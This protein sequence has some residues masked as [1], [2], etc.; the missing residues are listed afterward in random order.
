MVKKSITKFYLQIFDVLEFKAWQY[1][2]CLY[3]F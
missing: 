1:I 2:S 3:L